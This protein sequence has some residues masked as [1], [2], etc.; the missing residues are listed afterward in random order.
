[1]V[2]GYRPSTLKEALDI[3]ARERVTPYAGGTDL[4]I[5]PDENAIY[6]F[7]NKIPEMKKIVEDVEYIRIGAACT[8]TDVIESGLTPA[9]L[10]EAARKVGAPAIRNS[11]TIGGNICNGSP[12]AD[13]APIFFAAGAKLRLVNSSSE[14][15]LPIKDFYIGRNK[16]VLQ[17]DEL[18]VEILMPKTG[19]DNYYYKKVGAR[20]ALA[21]ARVSFAA[22]LRVENQKISDCITAF[23]AVSDVIINRE[24]I[25]AMLINKTIAEAKA[26]KKDYLAAYNQ[27]IVPIR[28]R[29]SS[30]YRKT[31]CMNLLRDFLETNGI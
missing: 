31:V 26:V 24:D 7:L 8:F 19:I 28:G 14:R 12:K 22:T 18:L 13:S 2:N 15:V 6:L 1:M 21:I 25:D 9:I 23:G 5:E 27:A 4:M 10:K 16:T 29:V 20:N 3:R 30:E 11:G 17:K